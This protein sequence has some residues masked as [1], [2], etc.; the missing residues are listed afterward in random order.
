M[1]LLNAPPSRLSPLLAL[2]LTLTGVLISGCASKLSAHT[3]T[4]HQLNVTI[5]D[6][7]G[8]Q[9]PTYHHRGQVY[10]QGEYGE[11]Y[12]IKIQNQS[13]KRREVVVTVDG[14]DVINGMRGKYE[15]RGYVLDPHS[16]VNIQGFRTS[17]TE[18][19]TF[20]FTSPSDSYS[21]RMGTKENVGVIG[22]ALFE[23]R[24]R[25]QPRKK[26]RPYRI[27]R[28]E[29]QVSYM[30]EEEEPDSAHYGARVMEGLGD[31]AP[32][33][34][35]AQGHAARSAARKAQPSEIGTQYGEGRYSEVEEVEFVRSSSRPRLVFS[36]SYDSKR[37][38]TRR[39]VIPKRPTP[40]SA[41]P[42]ERRYAPPPR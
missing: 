39:G 5:T 35:P 23:E 26:K 6:A 7:S 31:I 11:R 17:D 12:E 18:V 40:P 32:S 20:R 42:A 37:G 36:L 25:A 33:S 14:R 8:H 30:M 10:V 9:L 13:G 3:L 24:P 38:L 28:S 4:Q 16:T 27:S 21:S 15:H 19:A 34:P 1:P 2:T 22:V 41:F 29:P